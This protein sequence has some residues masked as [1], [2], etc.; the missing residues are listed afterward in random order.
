MKL[1]AL[2]RNDKDY[3]DRFTDEAVD[4]KNNVIKEM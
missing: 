1:K 4:G 3:T 2:P